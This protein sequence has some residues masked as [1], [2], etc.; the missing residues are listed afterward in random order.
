MLN[1]PLVLS[2]WTDVKTHTIHRML[3]NANDCG[4]IKKGSTQSYS[5]AIGKGSF[6]TKLAN[7]SKCKQAMDVSVIY[8]DEVLFNGRVTQQ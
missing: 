1:I 7:E 4:G 5:E 2:E 8:Y 3:R 6:L